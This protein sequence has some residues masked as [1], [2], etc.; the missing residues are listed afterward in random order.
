MDGQ[1]CQICPSTCV[2]NIVQGI[3]EGGSCSG[4][5]ALGG[6][7][8]TDNDCASLGP[9]AICRQMTSTGVVYQNGYCTFDCTQTNSCPVGTC[10]ST[11]GLFGE[12]ASLC[13]PACAGGSPCREPGYLCYS[14]SNGANGCWLDPP[15]P[16]GL[17]GA[18]CATGSQCVT[19]TG[20]GQGFCRPATLADGGP[21]GF[22]GGE[23]SA[24]CTGWESAD[25]GFGF[26][27]VYC[28]DGPCIFDGV[29]SFFCAAACST[30][31]GGQD[32]CRTGYVCTQTNSPP[33]QNFCEPA[34]SDP[35]G[36]CPVNFI[37]DAG[38]C[39]QGATCL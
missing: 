11:G 9:G 13:W 27:N 17:E 29:G 5:N 21:S 39:C 7:C 28:G 35:G 2:P 3:E 22:P 1:P 4:A 6:P 37:C 24:N 31:F 26:G 18:A 19:A 20:P 12:T 33:I 16:A 36:S 38:Y 32:V 30:P 23:C 8:A 14:F 15:A 34:C 25:S 10:I